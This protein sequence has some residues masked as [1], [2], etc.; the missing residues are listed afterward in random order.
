MRRICMGV[1]CLLIFATSALASYPEKPIQ[2]Y[3]MWGAGGAMDNVSR[4]ITPMVVKE[5]GKSIVLQ[6]KTGAT[7]AIATTFVANQKADGYSLLYGAENPNMYKVTNISQIDY[8]QFDPIILL[9]ANEGVM[10]VN[11][12]SKYNT[13]KDFID[14]AQN[15]E[16][17]KFGTTGPAGIDFIACALMKKIH[18][19]DFNFV[20]FDGEGDAITALMGG[21]ID[22]VCVGI[23]TA[24]ELINSGTI[25][26]LAV[27]APKRIDSVKSVPAVTEFYPNEYGK[28][29]PWGAFFGVFVRKGTPVEIRQ[30]L[31][32]AYLK[33]FNDP[34]FDQFAKTMGGVK[35]GLTGEEASKYIKQNKSVACWLMFD[36][37]GTDISPEKYNIPKPF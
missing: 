5:L 8:D 4:A 10:V 25:K 23:L 34:S 6:N 11:K 20:N 27:I 13:F 35:L 16:K 14:A 26:G 19:I 32:K 21:H 33:A 30:I 15:G 37:G 1:V 2:G 18:N 3:I 36:S 7:G 22:G 9:L 28:Y 24:A 17:F 29:L 31:E 12:N